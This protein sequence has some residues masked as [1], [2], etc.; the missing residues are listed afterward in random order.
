MQEANSGLNKILLLS[1][2]LKIERPIIK[3]SKGIKE[4]FLNSKNVLFQKK[5]INGIK[6]EIKNRM[7]VPS[8]LSFNQSEIKESQTA[9]KLNTSK[10]SNFLDEKLDDFMKAINKK[11]SFEE[12][13]IVHSP[14]QKHKNDFWGSEKLEQGEMDL[15]KFLKESANTDAIIEKRKK[16]VDPHKI[17]WDVRVHDI[18]DPEFTSE[19]EGE[20]PKISTS[21][22]KTVVQNFL[23]SKYLDDKLDAQQIKSVYFDNQGSLSK[24]DARRTDDKFALYSTKLSSKAP[25]AQ[26]KLAHNPRPM[27]FFK[28]PSIYDS[29]KEQYKVV[30][31]TLE[32]ENS[33]KKR[34]GNNLKEQIS[35]VSIEKYIRR[36]PAITK[37]PSSQQN[38]LANQE[39][40]AVYKLDNKSVNKN[41]DSLKN[42]A[43]GVQGVSQRFKNVKTQEASHSKFLYS[44]KKRDLQFF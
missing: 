23:N 13:T 29:I 30:S 9:K 17:V 1:T 2:K 8:E 42:L 32:R 19:E 18:F 37:K 21:A 28:K 25:P 24:P 5:K 4:I 40:F 33:A 16:R 39:S 36:A 35:K 41:N 22:T 44:G 43:I 14:H 12:P 10:Q 3:V 20:S 27:N 31:P 38:K 15:M 34:M 11:S 26:P 7:N 6:N